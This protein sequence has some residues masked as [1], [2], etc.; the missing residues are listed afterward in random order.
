MLSKLKYP[1][2]YWLR[3][4]RFEYRYPTEKSFRNRVATEKAVIRREGC[5][6]QDRPY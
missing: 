5:E 1:S 4:C 2:K 6:P 3:V